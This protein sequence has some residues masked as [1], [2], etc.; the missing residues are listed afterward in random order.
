M[1]EAGGLAVLVEHVGQAFHVRPVLGGQS[2]RATDAIDQNACRVREKGGDV[3]ALVERLGTP[4]LI[5]C[6]GLV[7]V[8]RV[9]PVP[10]LDTVEND[11]VGDPCGLASVFREKML[12]GGGHLTVL[13]TANMNTLAVAMWIVRAEIQPPLLAVVSGELGECRFGIEA[14]AAVVHRA[15]LRHD[16]T[17]VEWQDEGIRRSVA[18]E[19]GSARQLREAQRRDVLPCP[20]RRLGGKTKFPVLPH[21]DA[22]LD[23]HS[24]RDALLKYH[25]QR[26]RPR[27]AGSIHPQ[28]IARGNGARLEVVRAAQREMEQRPDGDGGRELLTTDQVK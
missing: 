9:A 6:P 11:V 23:A 28:E 18:G 17:L 21:G 5:L 4:S 14:R 25:G 27:G 24:S 22:A 19:N 15:G 1:F 12:P 16:H 10:S 26:I 7:V 2:F 20:R 13:D 3:I 8:R